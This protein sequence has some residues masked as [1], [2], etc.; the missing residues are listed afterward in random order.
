MAY[1]AVI[2]DSWR[3]IIRK[4]ICLV[5]ADRGLWTMRNADWIEIVSAAENHLSGKDITPKDADWRLHNILQAHWRGPESYIV[6]R[7]LLLV[8]LGWKACVAAFLATWLYQMLLI[9]QNLPVA[10][11][12][13]FSLLVLVTDLLKNCYTFKQWRESQ[14]WPN[15]HSEIMFNLPKHGFHLCLVKFLANHET[16]GPI[17]DAL[18]LFLKLKR[19]MILLNIN[20]VTKWVHKWNYAEHL[21]AT[22]L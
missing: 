8:E 21:D 5:T 1:C 7:L 20:K 4:N 16:G 2:T 14:K 11:S 15:L 12:N 3:E 10:V 6:Q 22:I 9:D 19:P 18:I 13:Q 17:L